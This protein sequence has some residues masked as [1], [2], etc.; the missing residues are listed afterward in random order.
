MNEKFYTILVGT[1]LAVTLLSANVSVLAMDGNEDTRRS[2]R[3]SSRIIYTIGGKEV[4]EKVFLQETK[5][6]RNWREVAQDFLDF[7]KILSEPMQIL[8]SPVR[9]LPDGRRVHDRYYE[10]TR[11]RPIVLFFLWCLSWQVHE[12][13]H[14]HCP[15]HS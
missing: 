3:S 7:M 6:V 10:L 12:Y 1:I 8:V 13:I 5:P 14:T 2:R 15:T 9:V 4:T 11:M